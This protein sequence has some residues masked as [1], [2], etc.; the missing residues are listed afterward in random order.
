MLTPRSQFSQTL[1]LLYTTL[2]DMS[3]SGGV[4]TR[5]LHKRVPPASASLHVFSTKT[6]FLLSKVKDDLADKTAQFPILLHLPH[7]IFH[8]LTKRILW[9]IDCKFCSIT[10]GGAVTPILAPYSV[11]FRLFHDSFLFCSKR[12]LHYASGKEIPGDNTTTTFHIPLR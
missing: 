7:D 2:Y 1:I 3:R 9:G 5:F 10:R 6:C 11:N 8:N 4:F 12:I